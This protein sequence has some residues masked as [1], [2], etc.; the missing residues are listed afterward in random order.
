MRL[1]YFASET[2]LALIH[3]EALGV[4]FDYTDYL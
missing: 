4:H 2:N 3:A 1:H